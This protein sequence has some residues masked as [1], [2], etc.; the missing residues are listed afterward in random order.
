[1]PGSPTQTWRSPGRI[2][3][4]G[5]LAALCLTVY[6]TRAYRGDFH[7]VRI[8]I[9]TE[10]LD[11]VRSSLRV[12]LPDLS[13]VAEGPVAVILRLRN[14]GQ[15]ERGVAATLAGTDLGRLEVEPE[16]M[17]TFNLRLDELPRSGLD[18]GVE[19]RADGDDWGLEQLEIA[20]IYGFSLRPFAFVIAPDGALRYEPAPWGGAMLVGPILLLLS[21]PFLR[22]APTRAV[23]LGRAAPAVLVAAL[24]VLILALPALSHFKV[25]IGLDALAICLAVAYGP[26]LLAFPTPLRLLRPVGQL[27]WTSARWL[28]AQRY[29]LAVSAAVA[30][31]LLAV[32]EFHDPATGFTSLIQFGREFEPQATP[33]MRALPRVVEPGSGYDG[34]FYA[35]LALDPLLRDAATAQA[36]DN[37][38]YRARRI[39]FA[40]SAFLLGLGQPRLVIE[41]FA[42]QNVVAWLLLAWLLCRWIRPSRPSD[43]FLWFCCMF[44]GGLLASVRSSL[45]EGPSLLLLG[46]TI[47]A[48]EA[49][50]MRLAT[51]LVALS[52]LG[53][54]T[55]LLS[56][57]TL[58]EPGGA[59]YRARIGRLAIRALAAALPLAL[60]M[61]YLASLFQ[62][63]SSGTGE[64]NFAWPMAAYAA[65]WGETLRELAVDGWDSYARFSLHALVSLPVQLA[66]LAARPRWDSAWWRV[67]MAYGLL[68]PILGPAVWQGAPGAAARVLLPMTFAFNVLLPR[69]AAFW[70]L[71][72]LGNLGVFYGFE[73]LAVPD[74]WTER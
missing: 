28:W 56:A 64:R 60:W 6:S 44:S 1:V 61:A 32:R 24:F 34:Q 23:D 62:V 73:A 69:N 40:W 68:M 5:V 17:T 4:L 26:A 29:R 14:D 65:K 42:L 57:G 27:I 70:P 43:L 35:Q 45:L 55:N 48:L 8:R 13:A 46:L 30:V 15:D 58:L 37:Y 59:S 67:G 11:A 20:N 16:G 50:R 36:L 7:R 47:V 22:P 33:A 53:R 3:A 10:P 12:S 52:G 39:L 71:A 66:V 72:V 18:L 74:L 25:L 2:L 19:L 41:V 38:E 21:L 49:G 63:Q 9:V 51:V 54:D 31:F